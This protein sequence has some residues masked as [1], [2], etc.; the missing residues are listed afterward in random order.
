MEIDH[1]SKNSTSEI[2]SEAFK[3]EGT[4][5]EFEAAEEARFRARLA[6]AQ[7]YRAYLETRR[8]NW[9][10]FAS[11]SWALTLGAITLVLLPYVSVGVS[12]TI[13]PAISY[14]SAFV[15]VIAAVFA[16]VSSFRVAI[17]ASLATNA[18]YYIDRAIV[19]AEAY[20]VKIVPG[21]DR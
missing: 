16:L 9:L 8:T 21:G 17:A 10:I 15:V 1:F 12:F 19:A 20:H 6:E 7:V 3:V 2:S 14:V 13:P 4:E 5:A 18:S 11:L